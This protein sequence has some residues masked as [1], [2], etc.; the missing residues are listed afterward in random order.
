MIFMLFVGDA[1]L[2]PI[3]LPGFTGFVDTWSDAAWCSGGNQI[4]YHT[5][6]GKTGYFPG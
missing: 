2:R 6:M 4:L 1:F 5:S 3:P